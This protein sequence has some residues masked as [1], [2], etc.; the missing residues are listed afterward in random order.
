MKYCT[1]LSV[2]AN[3][4]HGEP[5]NSEY[6]ADLIRHFKL[7]PELDRRT[8]KDGTPFTPYTLC[9]LLC[10][11]QKD[12]LGKTI[13]SFLPAVAAN[14]FAARPFDEAKL[15]KA[16]AEIG[17]DEEVINKECDYYR[18]ART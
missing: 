2:E 13:R 18:H 12:G 1:T 10:F 16:L 9:T 8:K 15:R 6:Y 4:Y 3:A 5:V 14:G 17:F 7:Q 11:V